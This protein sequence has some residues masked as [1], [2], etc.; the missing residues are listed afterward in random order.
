MRVPFPGISNGSGEDGKKDKWIEENFLQMD[1]STYIIAVVDLLYLY[2][3]PEKSSSCS[4]KRAERSRQA[5][6]G[7]RSPDFLVFHLTTVPFGD[8]YNPNP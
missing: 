5:E 4:S 2:Y 1:M 7:R 6:K 8:R 3:L